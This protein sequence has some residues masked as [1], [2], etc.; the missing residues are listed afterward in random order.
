MY[1]AGYKQ[2]RIWVPRDSEGNPVK[3][4]RQAFIRKLD[5][6]TAGWSKARLSRFFAEALKIIKRTIKEGQ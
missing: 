3:L 4:E 5:E 6:L 2:M 1:A